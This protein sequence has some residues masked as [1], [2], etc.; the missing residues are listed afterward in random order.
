VRKAKPAFVRFGCPN[1]TLFR[2]SDASEPYSRG[3][4][5]SALKAAPHSP[6][7]IFRTSGP[8]STLCARMPMAVELA[9]VAGCGR[10]SIFVGLGLVAEN[11]SFAFENR[12]GVDP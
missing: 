9:V 10:D 4:W 6:R 2:T 3:Q 1:P 5:D 7:V 12:P 8:E 11:L